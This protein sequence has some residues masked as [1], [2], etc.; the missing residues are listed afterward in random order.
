MLG[1]VKKIVNDFN[2]NREYIKYAP[3]I[4]RATKNLNPDELVDFIFSEKWKR[5]FWMIQIPSEIKFLLNKVAISKPKV[6]V[7]IGTKMGGTLF[8]FTKVAT[9]NAQIISIDFPDGHGGGYSNSRC[10]FYK[11]FAVPPQRIELIQGDSHKENTK[12]RLMNLL[13]G[14]KIDFLFIDGDHSQEGVRNDFEMYSPFV[15]AG[16]IIAFHDIKPTT[17]NSWSG[18]IP[19]WNS[20]KSKHKSEEYLGEEDSWGGI[21]VIEMQ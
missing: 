1:K 12:S 17:E 14:K 3:I 7:E 11:L 9:E 16:G 21:G 10:N 19:F 20:I 8:L 13:E 6:V 5:F 18:V 2:A 4:N 15:R